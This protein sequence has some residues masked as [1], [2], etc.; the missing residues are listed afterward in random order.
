MKNQEYVELNIK[1]KKNTFQKI[2]EYITYQ[3]LRNDIKDRNKPI[4]LNVDDFVTGCVNAYLNKLK[5]IET[6]GGLDDLGKPFRLKN[7]FK[8]LMI[9]RGLS[10]ND[11]AKATGINPV[12]IGKIFS[13]QNQPS[14]DFYIRLWI[15][16]DCPPID[17]VL[18]REE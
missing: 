4:D 13:N 16:F 5:Y 3:N 15:F 18:Y 10:Q 17:K 14:L 9:K 7:K 6:L 1:L 2:N 11:V 12:N 8:E